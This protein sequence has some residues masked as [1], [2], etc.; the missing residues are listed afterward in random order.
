MGIMIILAALTTGAA[1]ALITHSHVKNTDALLQNIKNGLIAYS[2]DYYVFVPS[3]TLRSSRPLWYALEHDG[4]YIE[5]SPKNKYHETGDDISD[6]LNPAQT[7][8][9]FIYRDAWKTELRYTCTGGFK[10][11]VIQSAGRDK[12]FDTGDDISETVIKELEY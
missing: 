11:A 1:F 12:Q 3:D 6:P 10:K 4:A 5:V 9:F 2:N 8:P 7:L